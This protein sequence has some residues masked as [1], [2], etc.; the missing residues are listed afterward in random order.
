VSPL[1]AAHG[2][3]D[4]SLWDGSAAYPLSP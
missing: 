4:L 3:A 2:A 1:P